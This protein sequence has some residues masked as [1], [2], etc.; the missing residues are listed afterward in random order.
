MAEKP[1][2]NEK[3][4]LFYMVGD[5][6]GLKKRIYAQ[7]KLLGYRVYSIGFS[8]NTYFASDVQYSDFVIRDA[9]PQQW[10]GWISNAEYVFTDSF[11]G[12]VFSIIFEKE[13]WCFERDNPADSLNE[14]SR[15]YNFLSI[16][17]L[18][19]RLLEYNTR[20]LLRQDGNKI[21]FEM[22]ERRLTEYRERS[23]K[24]IKECLKQVDFDA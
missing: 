19:D 22:V 15:L 24:F 16:S 5:S 14:N 13:F 8:K 2:T 9:G 20:L 12:S 11:H 10:L 18:E 6:K 7:C 3:Y 23:S 1:S 17:G 21:D 4:V